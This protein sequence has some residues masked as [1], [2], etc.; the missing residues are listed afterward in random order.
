MPDEFGTDGSDM[1]DTLRAID[2]AEVLVVGFHWLTER[3]LIDARRT[4]TIGPYV[5][6]VQPVRTPQERLHQLREIRPGFE[7]PESFVFLPWRGR[8]DAFEASGLFD[9]IRKRCSGDS[10]AE[11]DCNRAF[12]ELLAL[13]KKDLYQAISGGEKYHTLYSSPDPHRNN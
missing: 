11:E 5:R 8:V 4:A 2:Q 9:R 1:E 13:D 7:D 3:F 10:Q 12:N 6:V